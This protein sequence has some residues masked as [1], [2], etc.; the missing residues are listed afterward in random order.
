MQSR[1]HVFVWDLIWELFRIKVGLV[2]DVGFQVP[3]VREGPV[4]QVNCVEQ[5][6]LLLRTTLKSDH[7]CYMK[8]VLNYH[9][10]QFFLIVC[11]CKHQGAALA[12]NLTT[13]QLDCL[14]VD[15]AEIST[16]W[17]ALACFFTPWVTQACLGSQWYLRWPEGL[18]DWMTKQV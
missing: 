18:V 3:M 11:K 14:A 1:V 2:I 16:A 12:H 17:R 6:W 10:I 4:F 8:C 15:A 9:K 13:W 7:R 5:I